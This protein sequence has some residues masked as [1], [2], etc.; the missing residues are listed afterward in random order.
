MRDWVI[1]LITYPVLL[2]LALIFIGPTIPIDI[3]IL[4][5][6]A[7]VAMLGLSK[8]PHVLFGLRAYLAEWRRTVLARLKP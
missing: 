5:I 7:L 4:I 1:R 3:S 8:G 6:T 2:V